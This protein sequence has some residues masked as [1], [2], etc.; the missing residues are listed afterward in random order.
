MARATGQT[1]SN[2][3]VEELLFLARSRHRVELLGLLS[4]GERTRRDLEESTDMSQPTLG[5][6][7]GD[8]ERRHWVSN[9][10]DGAYSLTPIGSL[11]AGAIEE[12]LTVLDSSRQL[13]ELADTLPLDR[14]GFDLRHLS[15]ATVTTP[16][17]S[18]PLAHMRRFDE[19]A[20]NAGT[21]AVFSNVLACSPAS[22]GADGQ[23]EFLADI[24]DLV[25]TEEACVDGLDD[26]TLRA[27]VRDQVAAGELTLYRYGGSAPF[28][29]GCFD[30]I[31]GIVP[32]DDAGIP[33]GLIETDAP[34]IREWAEARFEELQENAALV[35]PDEFAG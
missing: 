4:S 26:P 33:T 29:L 7:L 20:R 2:D 1:G 10:H 16:S 27:L 11:L 23:A 35:T 6:I 22:G 9:G 18:D 31:V 34:P 32:V 15:T 19:R 25:V 3:P 17:E 12:L 8:F 28:L 24:D 13:A 14:I 5:R 21:V 30:D